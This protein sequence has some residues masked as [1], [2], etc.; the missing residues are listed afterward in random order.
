M[1]FAVLSTRSVEAPNEEGEIIMIFRADQFWAWVTQRHILG[2]RRKTKSPG[3]WGAGGAA[4][5]DFD[6]LPRKIG[7]SK[8][9]SV[10]N[11]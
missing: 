5:F 6:W 8:Q 10:R 3:R 9:V 2:H 7:T 4:G 11:A 1:T